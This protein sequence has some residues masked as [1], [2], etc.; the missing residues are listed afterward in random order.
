[1]RA[2]TFTVETK[3][4]SISLIRK[5]EVFWISFKIL[6]TDVRIVTTYVE[7]NKNHRKKR[8][9][10]DDVKEEAREG[11]G[12]QSDENYAYVPPNRNLLSIH[13]TNT[14]MVS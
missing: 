2:G 14:Y 10:N 5:I 12:T 9:C 7:Y 6:P 3:S 11:P 13:F 1:M 8:A 4:A